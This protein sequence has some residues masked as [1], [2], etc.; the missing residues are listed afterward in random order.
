MGAALGLCRDLELAACAGDHAD[1]RFGLA[2][3]FLLLSLV[4]RLARLLPKPGAWMETLKQFLAF[5]MFGAAAWL[6]W[7][8]SVQTG[9]GGVALVLGGLVLLA[10]GLWLRER[11]SRSCLS[12][13]AMG[14]RGDLG[15]LVGALYL[16]GRDRSA[17]RAD[18]SSGPEAA[19][20]SQRALFAERLAVARD[21]QRPVSSS[22]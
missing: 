7:V 10:F 5:P 21:E 4:P 13:A 6:V 20:D 16:G 22:T 11:T 3:P 8:L 14:C 12:A 1:P 2:L 19:N 9:S 15:A 17:G 18:E